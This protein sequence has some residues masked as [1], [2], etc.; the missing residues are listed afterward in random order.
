MRLSW[1]GSLLWGAALCAVTSLAAAEASPDALERCAQEKDEKARL[2]CYDELSAIEAG[3]NKP[4]PPAKPEDT[5]GVKGDLAR[6][7]QEEADRAA[8][9]QPKITQLEARIKS[10]SNLPRGHLR[11]VLDNGQIWEQKE[12]MSTFYV[13]SGEAVKIESGYLGAFWLVNEQ[14]RRTRVKR[15]E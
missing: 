6:K 14:G 1:T 3:R 11:V 15:V 9:Q 10:A 7:R 8:E 12:V 13:K 4:A 2:A 5:F